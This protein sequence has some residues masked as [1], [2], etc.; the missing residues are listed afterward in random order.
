MNENKKIKSEIWDIYFK[1][2][3]AKASKAVKYALI[4]VM[5]LMDKEAEKSSDLLDSALDI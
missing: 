5:I 1:L 4:D 3:E 2:E